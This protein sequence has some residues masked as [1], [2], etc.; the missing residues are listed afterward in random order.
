M[1]LGVEIYTYGCCRNGMDGD[2]KEGAMG[3]YA[4]RRNP[5][6][7]RQGDVFAECQRMPPL[8]SNLYY[9]YST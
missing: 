5:L 6:A 8:T 2:A 4:A 1:D 3:T 7:N 9:Q